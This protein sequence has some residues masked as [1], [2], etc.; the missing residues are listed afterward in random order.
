MVA[1]CKGKRQD[2]D[3]ASDPSDSDVASLSDSVARKRVKAAIP[4]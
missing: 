2:A 3:V 1:A 4:E